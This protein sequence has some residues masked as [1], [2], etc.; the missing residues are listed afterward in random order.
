MS[1]NPSLP[2]V[3]NLPSQ[4]ENLSQFVRQFVANEQADQEGTPTLA[5]SL[6]VDRG[7]PSLAASLARLGDEPVVLFQ[8]YTA[9][10]NA[11]AFRDFL[12]SFGCHHPSIHALDL[13]DMPALYRQL[14]IPVPDLKFHV[15]DACDPHP[16]LAHGQVSI[17]IQHGLGNCC[18]PS[19]WPDFQQQGAHLLAP[20]GIA[21]MLFSEL[22]E[23]DS[24]PS[25]SLT[26]FEQLTGSAWN[27]LGV[28]LSSFNLDPEQKN[29][30]MGKAVFD[31]EHQTHVFITKPSGRLEFFA[32]FAKF[33]A[34]L[35]RVGLI[36]RSRLISTGIDSNGI[37]CRRSQCLVTH[38]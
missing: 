38:Q 5:K 15:S 7:H 27:P 20:D 26:D 32:P 30:L 25:L 16:G 6:G 4:I 24:L 31:P 17:L 28:D 36:V 21:L 3:Q 1:S 13:H 34:S 18:P 10:S 37:R 23:P 8:G 33:E 9:P 19:R 11:R 22:V 12:A 35:H 14:N 29:A 2:P